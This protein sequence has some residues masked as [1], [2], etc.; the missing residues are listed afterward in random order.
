MLGKITGTGVIYL[1]A[2]E[3]R[4]TGYMAAER[5]RNKQKQETPPITENQKSSE[6]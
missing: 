5:Y 1:R 4:T 3:R 6:A 2:T